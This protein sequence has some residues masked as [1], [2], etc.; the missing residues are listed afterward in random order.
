MTSIHNSLAKTGRAV[1]L[2]AALAIAGGTAAGYAQPV[3]AASASDAQ[4]VYNQFR[5]YV[6]NPSSLAQARKYLINHIA[7][8]GSWYGTVMT[9]QLEN[10]QKAELPRF[11]EYIYPEHV[12][13]VLMDA[14]IS[15]D[16]TYTEQ[17]K[18]IKDPGVRKLLEQTWDKGY[19]LETSEGMYYPVMHYEGFKVFKPNISKDIAAYI[20]IMATES[21]TPSSFDAA[22]VITWDELI[23]RAAVMSDF[24]QKYPKSNRNAAIREELSYTVPSILLGA[25]NTPAYDYQTNEL[26]PELRRAYDDV[27]REGPGDNGVLKVLAKLIPLLDAAGNKKTPEV[28]AYLEQVVESYRDL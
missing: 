25:D 14:E 12:Q 28:S 18:R 24:V 23:G 7:E 1:L 17:L 4:A 3:S 9:L 27:L 22:I 11:S 8:A 21:N 2:G 20:D 13:Q 10:V 6:S 5:K 15:N 26:D 16:L 19:K